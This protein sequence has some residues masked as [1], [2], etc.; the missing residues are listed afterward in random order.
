[1]S[2]NFL[3]K[4]LVLSILSAF[5]FSQNALS[6]VPDFT[7]TPAD[8]TYFGDSIKTAILQTPCG[9]EILQHEVLTYLLSTGKQ[10]KQLSVSTG[11]SMISVLGKASPRKIR[12]Y[13]KQLDYR[14]LQLGILIPSEQP[15][16]LHT[17]T[18]KC[19]A[20]GNLE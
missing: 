15:H 6:A 4:F 8:G 13:R 2:K 19:D 9:E 16:S 11:H 20:N 10:V 7:K 1:M 5:T 17:M 18:F 12:V 14:I 3:S